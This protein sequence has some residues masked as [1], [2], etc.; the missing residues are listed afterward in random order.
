M[1]TFP[2]VE[3][4]AMLRSNLSTTQGLQGDERALVVCTRFEPRQLSPW[5]TQ[6]DKPYAETC[7]GELVRSFAAQFSCAFHP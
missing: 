1:F 3:D 2:C 5:K 7:F 6:S 4:R